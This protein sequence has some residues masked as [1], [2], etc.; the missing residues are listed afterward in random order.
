MYNLVT[1]NSKGSQLYLVILLLDKH[2]Y[3]Y[4]WWGH[5]SIQVAAL[6]GHIWVQYLAQGHYGWFGHIGDQTWAPPFGGEPY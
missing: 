6:L 5:K 3:S 2:Y 4:L 1:P